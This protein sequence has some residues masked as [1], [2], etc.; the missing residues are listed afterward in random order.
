MSEQPTVFL[1]DDDE[2]VLKSVGRLLRSNGVRVLPFNS[3][4][5]FLRAVTQSTPGCILLD[6][7]MPDFNGLEVQRRLGASGCA[8]PVIFLTG[9]ADIPIT[10]EAMKG[11]AIDFLT[12]PV[13]EAALLASVKTAFARDAAL[14]EAAAGLREYRERLAT[15][16]PREREVMELVVEGLL[17]KQIGLEL[18]TVEKTI[19]VHRA[20]VMEKMGVESLAELVRI[21]SALGIG[22]P[23]RPLRPGD[24]PPRI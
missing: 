4:A 17:N 8:Q 7:G 18:G 10:V 24:A 3:S 16:T 5:E 22:E 1:V 6:F 11:G 2:A 23:P 21:A 9:Q 13:D 12:K 15:L 20:R 19:K 14:R